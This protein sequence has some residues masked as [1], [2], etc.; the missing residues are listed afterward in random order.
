MPFQIE[1]PRA[2]L[3]DVG[4]TV[5]EERCFDLEAGISAVVGVLASADVS[6]RKPSLP[7]FETALRRLGVGAAQT[8]FVGDTFDEDIVGAKAAGLQPIWFSNGAPV[9]SGIDHLAVVRDW[10]QFLD[11]YTTASRNRMAFHS[12][13]SRS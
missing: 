10:T 12:D 6:S 2:V 5:L 3:F 9:D 4:N 13:R 11:F 1:L 8:W 7:I